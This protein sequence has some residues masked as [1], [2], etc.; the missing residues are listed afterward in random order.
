M[1]IHENIEKYIEV[2]INSDDI[3]SLIISA[4]Q[5]LGKTS[6]VLSKLS[7]MGFI[8]D[9]N[10]L[11]QSGYMTALRLY[12]F[13]SRSRILEIPKILIF[14]DIDSLLSNKTSLALLKSALS[15]ARGKRVVAYES[16]GVVERSFEFNGK[17]IL[18]TNNLSGNRNLKPLLD[19]A[20]VYNFESDPQEL[21][22]YIEG[23]L[24]KFSGDLSDD[25]KESVW[26]KVRRFVDSPDF[27]LRSVGR[28]FAFYR[29]DP[30]NWYDLW[31]KS[32]KK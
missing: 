28:A 24:D 30:E 9:Q 11:Y 1:Q 14:D 3:Y 10:Y 20:I 18:I 4:P 15:E 31:R 7:E 5:G 2:L 19:R 29:N 21:M 22:A 16:K 32:M 17:I 8:E 13:L 6:T 23:N 12:D 26:D 27:S 25:Q